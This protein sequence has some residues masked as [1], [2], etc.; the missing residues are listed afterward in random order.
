MADYLTF[1]NL[2]DEVTQAIKDFDDALLTT[3][4][5]AINQTYFEML[6][7][8]PLFPLFWLVDFDD[9]L[10]CVADM[11]ISGIT[12]ADPGVITVDAAHGLSTNDIVQVYGIVGTM[13]VLNNRIYKVNSVP[14]TTTLS[15]I[16]L[17]SLNAIATTG[18]AYTSDGTVVHRGRVL[19]VTGKN[20]QR[21]LA[22]R[23]HGEGEPMKEITW[24]ELE[25]ETGLLDS[26]QSRP[27][28]YMLR[29]NYSTAG[30]ENNQ[31]LWFP[32]SDG[33]YDLRYWFVARPSILSAVGDTP[34]MPPQFHHGITA[35]A[36]SRLAEYSV[37]VEN[38][39]IWPQIYLKTKQDMV[40]FNRQWWKE[41]DPTVDPSR[42][43][44]PY[45]I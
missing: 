17:D 33:A 26:S 3:A 30:V 10:A 45:M 13:S 19:G 38:A 18:L 29:K 37:Q 25:D 31:L 34:L 44:K 22:A 35:G 39:V 36:I 7:A 32:G 2:Y 14:A 27:T 24:K 15:L 42:A 41:H 11:T 8:D 5:H 1:Q 43:G 21:L 20:V 16:D 6:S 23:W 28:R 4:K 40:D 9:T 12:V